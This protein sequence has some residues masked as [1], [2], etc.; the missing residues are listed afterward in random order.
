MKLKTIVLPIILVLVIAALI[1]AFQSGP[2]LKAI[3]VRTAPAILK[4]PVTLDHLSLR[5]TSG[6]VS[7]A[8]LTIANPEGFKSDYAMRIDHF[9]SSVTPSSVF[10]SELHIVDI[11][12][13]GAT[14]ICDGLLADNHRLILSNI[15]EPCTGTLGGS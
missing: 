4:V 6:N 10:G 11:R 3:I 5:V 2:I 1:A 8:G 9:E 15:R 7:I 14:V 13:Q 12:L